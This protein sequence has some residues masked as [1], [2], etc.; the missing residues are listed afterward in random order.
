MNSK[1][2]LKPGDLVRSVCPEID[3]A[4]ENPIRICTVVGVNEHAHLKGR[5]CQKQDCFRLLNEVHWCATP[6]GD[7]IFLSNPT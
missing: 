4:Q 3:D 2:S 5:Q 7:E 1:E 6:P